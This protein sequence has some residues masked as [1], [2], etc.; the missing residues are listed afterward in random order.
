MRRLNFLHYLL[1]QDENTMLSKFFRVQWQFS[2]RGDWTEDLRQDMK[3][4]QIQEELTVLKNMS[5]SKFK[6]MVTTKARNY[7]FSCLLSEKDKLSKMKNLHYSEFQMQDYLNL[8]NM[9]V[10]Q[11]QIL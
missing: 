1:N 11:A 7:E 6:Q 2:T 9:A 4:F 3:D 8:Q 10:T 5:K